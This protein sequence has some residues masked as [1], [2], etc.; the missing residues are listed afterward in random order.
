MLNATSLVVV[1]HLIL[2]AI[3]NTC[4]SSLH[5]DSIPSGL[6]ESSESL[7]LMEPNPTEPASYTCCHLIQW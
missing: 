6:K 1:K 4:V 7:Y 2:F 5:G 3:H